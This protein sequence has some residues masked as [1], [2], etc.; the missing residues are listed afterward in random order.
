MRLSFKFKEGSILQIAM[1]VIN[2]SSSQS[3]LLWPRALKLSV[4]TCQCPT[5]APCLV[6]RHLF[7]LPRP[8]DSIF[9]NVTQHD[10]QNEHTQI[11]VKT[12]KVLS[13]LKLPNWF[14]ITC[15]LTLM[16]DKTLRKDRKRQMTGNQKW[17][18]SSTVWFVTR[19]NKNCVPWKLK[20]CESSAKYFLINF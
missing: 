12:I 19:L 10:P 14:E 7:K 15:K 18:F 17:L 3:C 5:G 20:M 6:T 13:L 8:L 11:S 9:P 16:S 2:T 1:V 4:I